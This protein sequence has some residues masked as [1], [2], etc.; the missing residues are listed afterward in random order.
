MEN[1]STDK[2][3]TSRP[4]ILVIGATGGTGRLIVHQALALGY[5][6]TALVRS[7]GKGH[8]LEG[9]KLIIGDACD[10]ATLRKAVKGR[11]VVISALGTQ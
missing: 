9:A 5:E 10:E 7:S 3:S 8:D 4:K 2:S 6:V 11:Q 1:V